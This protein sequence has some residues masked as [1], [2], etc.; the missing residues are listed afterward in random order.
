LFNHFI[1]NKKGKSSRLLPFSA[2]H[3]KFPLFS[4]E[5]SIERGLRNRGAQFDFVGGLRDFQTFG[6][7]RDDFVSGAFS[8]PQQAA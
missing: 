2:F 7:V 8:R 5:Q 1:E 4:G 6:D 3:F